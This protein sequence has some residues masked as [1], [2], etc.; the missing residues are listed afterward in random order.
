MKNDHIRTKRQDNCIF[1]KLLLIPSWYCIRYH[2]IRKQ[3][4]IGDERDYFSTYSHFSSIF[5]D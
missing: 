4:C 1:L 3:M 5:F 2:N